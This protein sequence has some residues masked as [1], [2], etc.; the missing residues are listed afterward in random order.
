[1]TFLA[2]S[3]VAIGF[4]LCFFFIAVLVLI[5]ICIDHSSR[6][7]IEKPETWAQICIQRLV[8]LAKESTTMRRVLD[9]MF[10]YFDSRQHWAPQNGLAMMVLSSMAYF[11]ENTGIALS[12]HSDINC[13]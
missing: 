9:P 3:A 12:Y 13:F 11:I 7:E 6:E 4:L 8:E 1:L 5:N 10:V 2:V